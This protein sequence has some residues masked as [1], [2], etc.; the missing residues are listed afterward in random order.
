MGYE[1]IGENDILNPREQILKNRGITEELLNVGEEAVEDYN[2]YD[3]IIEGCELLMKHIE[4]GNK[5]LII[6]D[7]DVDGLTSS[8]LLINYICE[9]FPTANIVSKYHEGKQHG[10]SSDIIVNDDISLVVIPDAG[11]ND[12]KE[13][14]EL[15]ERGIEVLV[16][17]HHELE[18]EYPQY[19]VIINNQT[20]ERVENKSLSG[21][22]VVYKF[23]C[24]FAETYFLEYP[25]KFIDM[26]ALGNIADAM[27]TKS[28]ETRY[29]IKE[30]LKHIE[31]PFFKSL[32][33]EKR[34]GE[35]K[36]INIL[37]VG[38][39]IAPMI[40]GCIRSGTVLEKK[41]LYSAMVDGVNC[42]DVARMCKNAKSRQDS[43]V[44][45]DMAKIEKTL[46]INDG[47]KVII[48]SSCGATK[49][50]T[51]L[52]AGKLC[53]KY[54]LPVFLYSS[55]G[56]IL[57]GSSRG[58]GDIDL[59]EDLNKS[60][61]GNGIGH[62][63]AFGFNFKKENE[64]K[65][66]DYFNELYKDIDFGDSNYKVDFELYGFELYQEFIDEIA[67]MEGEW[68]NGLDEPL[69][70][71]KDIPLNLTN[72][73]I[74]GRLN[75][76]WDFYDIKFIKKFASNSWKEEYINKNMVVDVIAKCVIDG[77]TN[78]GILEIV[79][80]IPI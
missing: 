18:G 40:N 35:L 70:A 44:K 38:W 78:K 13:I 26:V 79:D 54:K 80:I 19:G 60:G 68:G 55:N 77:Y 37:D 53:S 7:S 67:D 64:K 8:S 21:V 12:K 9:V 24:A 6:M 39:S 49:S 22:G 57:A 29:Y 58:L 27:D 48:A 65:I 20:S 43:A 71:I 2:H 11:T 62:S 72:D 23:L 66:K 32:I 63:L 14:K 28:A 5:I 1:L 50:K 15:Y 52:I 41:N 45:R 36:P 69:V 56:D 73:N 4:E 51:G 76:I 31:N 33:K 47:D 61:L 10:L 46:K 3:N 34:L 74:K 16:I 75:V 25:Y 59:K 30:G 17:D 42:D